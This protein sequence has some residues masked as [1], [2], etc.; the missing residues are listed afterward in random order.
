MNILHVERVSRNLTVTC[1]AL[2]LDS[3]SKMKF[4]LLFLVVLAVLFSFAKADGEFIILL[5][6]EKV[7]YS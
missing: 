4:Q 3:K 6:K 2:T 7:Q 1:K 5:N